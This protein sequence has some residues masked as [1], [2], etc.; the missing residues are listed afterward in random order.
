MNSNRRAGLCALWNGV[1]RKS[2]LNFE[3]I[4]D[5]Q[6]DPENFRV[7]GY[8]SPLDPVDH[9][10]FPF[11]IV[12]RKFQVIWLATVGEIRES[13]KKRLPA[14]ELII[15]FLG[16]HYD[17]ELLR[18]LALEQM[19]EGVHILFIG[20]LN[21]AHLLTLPL[22]FPLVTENLCSEKEG[23]LPCRRPART[24]EKVEIILPIEFLA[25]FLNFWQAIFVRFNFAR[26]AELLSKLK[27]KLQ[28]S[29]RPK[30]L[31]VRLEKRF[32]LSLVQTQ[33]R[34]RCFHHHSRHQRKA[35]L[36]VL[37]GSAGALSQP[38][39]GRGKSETLAV[40][41]RQ[42]QNVV[43][44][45]FPR[46]R[47]RAG[48]RGVDFIHTPSFE[49]IP[50]NER[51]VICLDEFHLIKG[52]WRAW[53]LSELQ[54]REEVVVALPFSYADGST[55]P[56]AAELLLLADEIHVHT[57][58]CWQC[59]QP[60]HYLTTFYRGRDDQYPNRHELHQLFTRGGLKLSR[61]F[62][63]EPSCS[64]DHPLLSSEAAEEKDESGLTAL[65]LSRKT[66]MEAGERKRKERQ[67]RQAPRRVLLLAFF[68]FMGLA[69]FIYPEDFVNLLN[70][71]LVG[72]LTVEPLLRQ[73]SR[74]FVFSF[75]GFVNSL[76]EWLRV[77]QLSTLISLCAFFLFFALSESVV[78]IYWRGVRRRS[79][80]RSAGIGLFV[81][82]L[83]LI[84]FWLLPFPIG[85]LMT[86]IVFLVS[87]I[88]FIVIQEPSIFSLDVWLNQ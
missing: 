44:S 21:R 79:K 48:I 50:K 46:R 12:G 80:R 45:G 53:L 52:D 87:V 77:S 14:P 56:V 65:M 43:F 73:P 78:F 27:Q 84:G 54:F 57:A 64:A 1:T 13:L 69:V 5:L 58:E 51:K 19:K 16:E 17:L 11:T 4:F 82:I 83:T 39:T 68:I 8:A 30:L 29:L 35:K 20:E 72:Y 59:G 70:H 60:A 85:L 2:P 67:R 31:I 40:L 75:L 3:A 55:L 49:S 47:S 34:D 25:D 7:L 26:P 15:I 32:G 86:G 88:T 63:W 22:S 66:E 38:T 24:L 81:P 9:W 10:S 71:L 62:D 76:Q 41:A 74:T 36:T 23:D 33:V 28:N 42:A 6:S 37:F 61:K 18:Q